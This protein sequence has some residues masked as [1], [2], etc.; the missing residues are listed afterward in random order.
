MPQLHDKAVEKSVHAL[1]KIAHVVEY[2]N[3]HR[4]SDTVPHR[5]SIHHQQPVNHVGVPPDRM[6]FTQV[7]VFCNVSHDW[8]VVAVAWVYLVID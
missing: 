1:G 2:P 4:H 6:L 3:P 8:V 7:Y 5:G